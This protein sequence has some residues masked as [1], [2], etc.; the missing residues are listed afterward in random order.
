MNPAEIG[1]GLAAFTPVYGRMRVT[2]LAGGTQLIDD[3]YNANP[4]SMEG[5]I[6]TLNQLRG[7]ARSLLVLGDMRELGPEAGMLH[8]EVGRL[9]ARSGL[10]K[11][12]VC[13]DFATDVASGARQGGMA[14]ADIVTGSRAEI[15]AALLRELK[16]GDWVLVKGSRAMGMEAIVKA[17]EEWSHQRK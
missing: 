14:D 7:A 15:Q 9:A 13:G 6:A 17:L 11:L 16:A 3:T 10:S 4:A 5:A 2:P 1:Q 8:Q 12:W